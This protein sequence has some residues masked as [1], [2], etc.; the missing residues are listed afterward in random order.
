MEQSYTFGK[1]TEDDIESICKLINEQTLQDSNKIVI[2]PIR[3]REAA[4][5]STVQQA[6]LFVA[7][8]QNGTVVG[9]KKLFL[10]QNTQE[11]EEILKNEIRCLGD[12]IQL[13]QA[14]IYNPTTKKCTTIENAPI[15]YTDDGIYIY[16]GGDFT[17][18]EHRK[19]GIN[20]KL[21]QTALDAIK[22]EVEV[23]KK[24]TTH[25]TVVFGLV[26]EN[27]GD[28]INGGRTFLILSSLIPFL[29]ELQSEKI[30]TLTLHRYQ[31]FKPTFN[32]KDLECKPLPD[33]QSIPG[34]G[35]VIHYLLNQNQQEKL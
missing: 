12:G 31:A 4:V 10:I 1:A 9:Y 3:F 6:R 17:H 33:N 26:K 14:G 5:K 16:N 21:M 8:D 27:A 28:S 13:E 25:L 20:T 32:P 22:S 30:N 34:Y 7:R 23:A 19:L 35:C 2:V 11:R 24:S 15:N 29:Q 18:P